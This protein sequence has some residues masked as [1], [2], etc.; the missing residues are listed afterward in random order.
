VLTYILNIPHQIL[1]S[2]NPLVVAIAYLS[3]Y[4]CFSLTYIVSLYSNFYQEALTYVQQTISLPSIYSVEYDHVSQFTTVTIKGPAVDCSV[5]G[6]SGKTKTN[7][8]N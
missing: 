7:K 3:L 8:F 2:I 6:K 5:G 4:I 1:P